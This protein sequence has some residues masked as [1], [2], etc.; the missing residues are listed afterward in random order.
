MQTFTIHEASDHPSDR[1]ERAERLIMVKDGFSLAAAVLTPFW[2]IA[3]RLWLALLAYVA[4]LGVFELA[5]W[6][7][8]LDQQVAGWIVLGAHLLVGFEA[9]SIRR[10]S[11]GRRGYRLVGSVSGRDWEECERRFLESWL[12]E[13]P[14]FA[15]A[16]ASRYASSEPGRNLGRLAPWLRRT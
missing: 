2:M 5:V 12:K 7:T 8:G 10:W 9:D 16:A 14:L 6:L 15:G 13:Q 4:F 1:L 11:L 3:H